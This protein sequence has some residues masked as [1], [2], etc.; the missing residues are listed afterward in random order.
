VGSCEHS[1]EPSDFIKGGG[2]LHPVP[3]D[4]DAVAKKKKKKTLLP[5]SGIDFLSSSLQLSNCTD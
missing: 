5:L 2:N 3:A 1:I 4:L